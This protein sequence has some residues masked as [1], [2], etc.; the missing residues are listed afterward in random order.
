MSRIRF[1]RTITQLHIPRQQ[2]RFFVRDP[3]S[4]K[5]THY[6]RR[7]DLIDSIR[8][9]LRSSR[10]PTSLPLEL[11][12]N[13]AAGPIRGHPRYPFCAKCRLCAFPRRSPQRRRP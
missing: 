10:T 9:N 8:L 13:P 5:L 6:I 11:L 12:N 1:P 4:N 2:V 7:A 3:F